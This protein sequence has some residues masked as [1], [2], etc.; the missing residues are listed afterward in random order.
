MT[1]FRTIAELEAAGLVDPARAAALEPVAARYAVAVTPA[2]AA[3][4]DKG[5]P[6]DPIARQFVPDPAELDVSPE[7]MTDPIGDGAHSP[8]DGIVHRYPDRVLLKPV[9]VCAVYCRFCF[10]REV[11][12]Q[13]RTLSAKQLDA[14]LDYIR[15]HREIWEVILTGGDPLVLSPRRLGKIVAALGADPMEQGL[16]VAS[17]GGDDSEIARVV[18]RAIS[19]CRQLRLEYYKANEDEFS[20][21]VVEPYALI[22]GREGWYVA[23]YDPAREAVRHFRLDRVKTAEVLDVSFTPRPEV[24]P[25]SD[26]AGWPSTPTTS[27]S[28]CASPTASPRRTCSATGRRGSPGRRWPRRS[29]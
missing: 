4:I 17:G 26:V 1:T 13:G 3:L 8:V 14:A 23:S 16:Q 28:S 29:S 21:R 19:D 5:D 24:D 6:N 18:S 7:E 25:A 11:V 10:R 20:E 27:R 12:G 9:H 2:I 15:T 22:N